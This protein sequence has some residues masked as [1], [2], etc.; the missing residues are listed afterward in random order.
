[1]AKRKRLATVDLSLVDNKKTIRTS[2]TQKGVDSRKRKAGLLSYRSI[3][4]DEK[5]CATVVS[6]MSEGKSKFVVA[7]ALGVVT[8]TLD[9]WEHTYEEFAEALHLGNEASRAWWEELARENIIMTDKDTRFNVQLWTFNMKNR[10]KWADKPEEKEKSIVQ[11]LADKRKEIEGKDDEEHTAEVLDILKGIS[12]LQS[13]TDE[14][15]KTEAEQ[16]HK[17]GTDT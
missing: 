3:K 17:T 12:A 5:M 9:A 13:T 10:F 4:Y 8:A 11:E 1:M 15:V 2:E 6:L 14:A 7:K 16:V